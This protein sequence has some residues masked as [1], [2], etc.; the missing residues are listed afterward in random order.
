MLT[1]SV[2]YGVTISLKQL[3]KLEISERLY[4]GFGWKIRTAGARRFT[5]KVQGIRIIDCWEAGEKKV[6][7]PTRVTNGSERLFLLA[8]R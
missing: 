4:S 6:Y 8:M 3:T 5:K 2:V 7:A 1:F